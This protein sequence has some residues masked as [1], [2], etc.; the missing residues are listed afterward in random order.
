MA[1]TFTPKTE[2][3][4]QAENLCPEG[5]FPFTVMESAETK[6]KGGNPMIKLKV[7]VHGP[8]GFDYHVFDYISDSFLAHKFRH[9][10]FSVGL[11]PDYEKGAVNV[12]N[13]A[14]Q[15]RGGYCE[16]DIEPSKNG[17]PAKNKITDYS[18]PEDQKPK[19]QTA[20]PP[21][22]DDDVPF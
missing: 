5:R 19:P 11:G 2:D 7:N 10:F 17:Y 21:P 8:E 16:V 9:F 14:L 6:S 4:V 20:E 12:A 22:Q 15:G 3:E 18:V 1:Y 13:N